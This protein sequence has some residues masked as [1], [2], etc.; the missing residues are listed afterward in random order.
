MG[1]AAPPADDDDP[2]PVTRRLT[3]WRD[4]FS[5]EDGEL[6]RYDEPGNKEL[7]ETI[8]AGRAPPHLFGVKFNQPLQLV[9]AQRTTE[10]YTPPPKKPAQPFGGSGNRLGSP[11][12]DFAGSGSNTPSMPGGMR[13]QGIL[14]GGTTSSS[15][16]A[17]APAQTKFEVDDSKPTTNVQVRLGDGTR[18][19]VIHQSLIGLICVGWWRGST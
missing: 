12:P 5:I 19:A 4:G 8:Q 13:P 6:Y 9:V 11:A 2:E 7:L 1:G 17:P 15:S 14:Q 18:C 10:A 16:S 3:F